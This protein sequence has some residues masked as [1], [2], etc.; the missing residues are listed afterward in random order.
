MRI[1]DCSSDVCSSDLAALA[2]A[3]SPAARR[4][5]AALYGGDLLEGVPLTES[6]ATLVSAHRERLR[7]QALALV[8]ALSERDADDPAARGACEALANRRSEERRVGKEGVSPCRT[9]WAP[10]H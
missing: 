1:S 9:R 2:G 4:R 7:R 3:A 5:A 8:E 6:L 10:S